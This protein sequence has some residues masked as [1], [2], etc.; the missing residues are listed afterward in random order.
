MST[1]DVGVYATAGTIPLILV[2]GKQGVVAYGQDNGIIAWGSQYGISSTGGL[3]GVYGYTNTNEEGTAGVFGESPYTDGVRGLGAVGVRGFG[4][5]GVWGEG[6][7]GVH[8]TGFVG[9]IGNST[10]QSGT[11]VSGEATGLSSYG[12]RGI[13]DN[14]GGTGVYGSGGFGTGVE[15]IG[16][17]GVKGTSTVGYGVWGAGQA[18]VYGTSEGGYGV[19][20]E[21]TSGTGV[22]GEGRT[23]VRGTSSTSYEFGVQGEGYSG[24]YGLSTSPDGCG[25]CFTNADGG[26]ALYAYGNGG[27]ADGAALRVINSKSVDGMAAYLT[28]DSGY[29]NAHL[30]NSGNGEV[31]VLQSNGGRFI[32][33]VDASWNARFRL[34]GNGNAYADGTWNSGGAD[35]AEM[36]PAV[37]GLE[38]G[39]VLAIGPDGTLILSS[40]PYQVSVAGVY[41]T[42]P[43]FMGGQPVEGEAADTVPLAVV[44]VVPVKASAENGPILPG[45]LLVTSSLA[46]YAM[47]AGHNP[48]QGTVIGKALGKLEAGTGIIKLL[49]T[50]Q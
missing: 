4:Y 33:A 16:E 47:K 19:W 38:P 29:A 9:V 2:T 13:A 45:D 23:G 39:D 37:K 27:T 12:V 28:N 50:L 40:E 6:D 36:L 48:P 43:G 32:R 24:V 49:A 31:L 18:G 46:G 44:G 7:A 1:N 8:G 42:K 34:E 10:I 35:F 20:G 21:S 11:G 41:S 22:V 5:T 25:G 30:Q 17:T 14:Y 15:G 3:S 26:I